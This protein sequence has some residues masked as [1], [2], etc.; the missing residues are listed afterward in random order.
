MLYFYVMQ[1]AEN[2]RGA[3]PIGSCPGDPACP[4][5]DELDT[6]YSCPP[7]GCINYS[8]ELA[9]AYT[10]GTPNCDAK[11]G[12]SVYTYQGGRY[13]L[14]VPA[15][16]NRLAYAV[17]SVAGPAPNVRDGEIV[18]ANPIADNGKGFARS[19]AAKAPL[20]AVTTK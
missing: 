12:G 11:A 13:A 15:N 3:G 19:V 4:G 8:V 17:K 16:Q 2:A 18:Q 7:Q 20:C 1:D 14:P 6:Y 5:A 10:P 9:G